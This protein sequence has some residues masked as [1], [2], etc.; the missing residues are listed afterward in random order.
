MYDIVN[1]REES[2]K[3][4]KR[5]SK[6]RQSQKSEAADL[7]SLSTDSISDSLENVNRGFLEKFS[8]DENE[9]VVNKY[10]QVLAENKHLRELN[11]ILR[12][13]MHKTSSDV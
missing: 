4:K 9:D 11:T 6:N 12:E 13:E 3:Y 5:D 10:N 8:L 7:K 2:F 1:M